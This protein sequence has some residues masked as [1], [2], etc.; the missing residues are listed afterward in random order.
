MAL[1][2][3]KEAGVSLLL[4]A[5]ENC[6][7]SSGWCHEQAQSDFGARTLEVRQAHTVPTSGQRDLAADTLR[8]VNAVILNHQCFVDVQPRTIVRLESESIRAP[9]GEL[10]DAAILDT[11]PLETIRDARKTAIKAA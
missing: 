7:G 5:L 6:F 1:L 3:H 2:K 11:E 9:A 8:R 10:A 4:S